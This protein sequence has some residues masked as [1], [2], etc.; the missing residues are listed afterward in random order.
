MVYF[1][2][3]AV[4]TQF[5]VLWA[6]ARAGEATAERGWKG[7]RPFPAGGAARVS[8]YPA[9]TA[10]VEVTRSLTDVIQPASNMGWKGW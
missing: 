3:Q 2:R 5:T 9:A 1:R 7:V 10:S 6:S 8:Q 4:T